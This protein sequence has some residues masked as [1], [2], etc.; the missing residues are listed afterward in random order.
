M[1]KSVNYNQLNLNVNCVLKNKIYMIHLS[2]LMKI[3]AKFIIN[4][5][6]YFKI[7]STFEEKRD[8]LVKLICLRA[9]YKF[10][11]LN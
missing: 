6:Q 1:D 8:L 2:F 9:C 11:K 3:K 4:G 5:I 10:D 7:L